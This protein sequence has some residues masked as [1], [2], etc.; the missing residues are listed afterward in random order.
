MIAG[1]ELEQPWVAKNGEF[2]HYP[3][4]QGIRVGL[5]PTPGRTG[6]GTNRGENTG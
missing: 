5:V 6:R 3:V 1:R 4:G 2:A